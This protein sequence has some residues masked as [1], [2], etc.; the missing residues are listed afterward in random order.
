MMR[1]IVII[2]FRAAATILLV[3][4]VALCVTG[5]SPIFRFSDPEPFSGPDIFNPYSTLDTLNGWKRANFHTHTRVESIFNECD[6]TAEEALRQYRRFGY[7]I[8]TFSNHQ[9]LTPHPEDTALQVNVYEH[10]YNLFKF[11]KL[12][13]GSTGV[14]RFDNILPLLISQKQWQL[15]YLSKEADFVQMNHPLRT[16]GTSF[17][18]MSRLGSYRI[19]ELD[20]GMDTEQEYWDWA[21]S[22]GHY[23]FG[24]AN[25]DLHHLDRSDCFAVRC[26]WI[27][28]PSAGYG[29]LKDA[30]LSGRYFSMRVPDFGS[31]DW[32]V[33]LEENRHLPM[34]VDI[35]AVGDSLYIELS[36][37][38][39]EI[40]LTGDGHRLTGSATGTDSFGCRMNPSDSYAR[41]T[42]YFDNGVVIYSNPFARYDSK[43]SDSPYKVAEHHVDVMLTILYNFA[44]ALLAAL[45]A[46]AIVRLWH[47]DVKLVGEE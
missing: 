41:F 35:G 40:K 10:G 32:D 11:H 27:N 42:V 4:V 25:D 14:N 24:L 38:A 28:T 16:V 45:C 21:L 18:E 43:V 23:S 30:L 34:V 37:P 8:V 2:P 15:D 19:I 26:N 39:R 7:D 20:S 31:G 12:V 29:D 3:C 13:Y 33:K 47:K 5:V 44:L 46:I 6:Y 22:A 1:Q 9:R 17:R 36:C